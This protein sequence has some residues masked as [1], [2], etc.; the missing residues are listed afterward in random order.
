MIYHYA[1]MG[2]GLDSSDPLNRLWLK[3]FVKTPFFDEE[4]ISRLFAGVQ[5]MHID[6]KRSLVN[7]SA[8]MSGKTRAF[9]IE[10]VNVEAFKQ[11]FF[12]RDDEE[13]ILAENHASLQKLL[14]A[15]NAS[16]GKKIF[17]AVI[18][19]FPFKVLEGA[20]F[21]RGKNIFNGYDFISGCD[22]YKFVEA[23]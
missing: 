14:D 8:M 7:L 17:F 12:I 18:P 21:I 22:F 4:T 23:M 11:I 19:N 9:F 6:L 5:K 15:M 3:Y 16:R 20:G 1:G 13:I 10:P 2:Y